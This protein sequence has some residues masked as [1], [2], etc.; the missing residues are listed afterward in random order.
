MR[1]PF[2]R[3]TGK[4]T[5]LIFLAAALAWMLPSCNKDIDSPDL[6]DTDVVTIDYSG[7]GEIIP[8]KYI[9]MLSRDAVPASKLKAASTSQERDDIVRA[10]SDEILTANRISI[11]DYDFVYGTA[12][13]GFAASLDEKDVKKLMADT[14]IAIVEPDRVIALGPPG[15]MKKPTPPPPPPPPGQSVPWGI[16]RVGSPTASYSGTRKA[17]IIDT[18]VDLTHPDLNVNTTLAVNYVVG[19]TS[20]ADQNGHGTHVAGTI[21]AINNSIG[22]VGVA[23]GVEVVPVRVLDKKGSGTTSGII[24]GVNYV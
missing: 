23:P 15:M 10:A 9:V 18:G 20:A 5:F 16:T 14:R 1:T 2:F 13:Q 17:W 7:S 4:M 11:P 24:A 3:R 6:P 21:G 22:V 8:G 19:T 12:I